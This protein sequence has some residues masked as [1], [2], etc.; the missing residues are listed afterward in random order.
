MQSTILVDARRHQQT[1]ES[2]LL[3]PK[4][5]A[6]VLGLDPSIYLKNIDDGWEIRLSGR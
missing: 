5:P 3:L 1:P 4:H 6:S 2:A